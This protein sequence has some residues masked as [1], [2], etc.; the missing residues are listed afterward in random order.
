MKI[1]WIL[2]EGY[3]DDSIYHESKVVQFHKEKPEYYSGKLV[4]I[5]YTEVIE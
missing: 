5:I 1:G 3:Y 2:Y 4:Q